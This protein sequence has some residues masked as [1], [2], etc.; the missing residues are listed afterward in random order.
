LPNLVGIIDPSADRAAL[1]ADLDRMIE[2]IDIPAFEYQRRTRIAEGVALGNVLSGIED[3][4]SQPIEDPSG[5]WLMLDGEILNTAE[6]RADLLRSD[7][8]AK[9]LDDAG[10]ALALFGLYGEEAFERFFGTWNVVIVDPAK[11]EVLI[12]SDR[13]GSRLLYCAHDGRRFTFASEA[14][15]VIAGRKI[16]TTANGLGLVALLSAGGQFGDLT[17]LDEIR[18]VDPGVILRFGIEG[19]ERRRYFKLRFNE[20]G[21]EMSEDDYADAFAARLQRATERAMKHHD[22]RRIG[23]TLSGGLDSRSIA[24]SIDRRHL[25]LPAI[26]YGDPDSPDVEYAAQLA[27]LIG[28]D[29]LYIERHR[30]ELLAES[31]EALE[32]IVGPA[33]G[34]ER[35]FFGV[36]LDRVLWRSEGMANFQGLTSMIWHP[37]YARTMRVALNGACGDALTG[38]HLGPELLLRPRRAQVIER[39]FQQ[40]Y[41]Q[42]RELVERVLLPSTFRRFYGELPGLF[43]R[44]FSEIESDEAMAVSS[45]WD[46]ENRQRRGA[47]SGF[48]ME[49]YF[50]SLRLPFLDYGLVDLL[51]SVP[52]QWRFQQRIYKRM[53]VRA[54]PEARHVP[55][56]YTRGRITA[57]PA[58]E[59][60]R[61]SFNFIRS[62]AQA[63]FRGGSQKSRWAIRDTD[64]LM[65]EDP[66]ILTGVLEWT[67]SDHFA[68][69]VLDAAGVRD[70]VER[71]RR[72]EGQGLGV[73]LAHLVALARWH[74]WGLS[75]ERIRIPPAAD[76]SRFGVRVAERHNTR[77][78][79]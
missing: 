76:P 47:F 58:F 45:I 17:W 70:L 56:A 43:A 51:A 27:Q 49:R 18:V 22:R 39:L 16:R 52:P 36:Q 26:T 46:M 9:K 2:A 67:R 77:R 40:A 41:W 23:I 55:W 8:E 69:N 19:L 60:A 1:E 65:R 3:N 61:E 62:R 72:G 12:A 54:F 5:R 48:T 7:I 21:P 66:E 57:S 6:L 53:I 33:K 74:E 28:L 25:P 42:R 64:R 10:L 24:L 71:Y 35:G 68:S 4:L 44:Q 59:L 73:L 37:I 30:D 63:R 32:R 34:G 15:A 14:K 11:R 29:H 13:A 75:G 20:R 78:V 79:E 38:S 31:R 50:C